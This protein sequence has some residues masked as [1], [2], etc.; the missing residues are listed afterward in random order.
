MHQ[1]LDPL[2][3]IASTDDD[4]ER[5]RRL[6]N[7]AFKKRQFVAHQERDMIPIEKCNEELSGKNKELLMLFDKASHD[8]IGTVLLTIDQ[9]PTGLAT[10]RYLSVSP[11]WWGLDFGIKLMKFAEGKAKIA[12]QKT[13]QLSV[14]Y[15]PKDEKVQGLI[16]WYAKIQGYRRIGDRKALE[17][18]RERLAPQYAMDTVFI[19]FEKNL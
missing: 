5:C 15:H 14:A 7:E 4:K 11:K 18:E 1:E 6:I 19:F 9:K 8:L 3:E 17:K 2:F 16:D 12:H 13:I 10:I